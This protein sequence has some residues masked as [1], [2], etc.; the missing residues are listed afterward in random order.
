MHA[1]DS[2]NILSLD[3]NHKFKKSF[4]YD[5]NGQQNKEKKI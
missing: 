2:F 3:D 5:S 1:L 4:F